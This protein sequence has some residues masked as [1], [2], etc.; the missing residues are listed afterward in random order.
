M[1]DARRMEVAI[2][3]LK[4]AHMVELLEEW[5]TTVNSNLRG[6]ISLLGSPHA[7]H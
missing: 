7:L 5:T 2:L 1:I 6:I 3:D 4:R